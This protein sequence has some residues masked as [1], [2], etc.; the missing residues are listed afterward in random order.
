MSCVNLFA[1]AEM[2]EDVV[3]DVFGGDFGAG[4]FAEVVEALAEVFGDKIGGCLVG[5][6]FLGAAEGFEGLLQGIVVA[7]VCHDGMRVVKIGGQGYF[8]D[9][10]SAQEVEAIA[11]GRGDVE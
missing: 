5:D 3:E 7:D 6:G 11:V 8:F 9:Q 10:S 4:D 2:G 1:H